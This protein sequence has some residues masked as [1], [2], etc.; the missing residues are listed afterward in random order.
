MKTHIV[1]LRGINVSGKNIIKMS[2]LKE[3]LQDTGFSD[4]ETYIQSGNILLSSSLE[5]NAEISSKVERVIKDTFGL[6][7]PALVLAP[8]SLKKYVANNPFLSVAE[9]TKAL[10]ICFLWDKPNHDSIS[11]VESK[12]F[13]PDDIRIDGKIIYLYFPEGSAKTKFTGAFLE[14]KLKTRATIRNWRT[15]QTLIKMAVEAK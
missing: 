8:G 3:A 7:V 9:D 5:S 12:Y 15:C 14:S 4:V 10:L 6:N 11:F 1:L 13:P 2:V